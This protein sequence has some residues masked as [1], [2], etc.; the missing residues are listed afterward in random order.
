MKHG[1]RRAIFAAVFALVTEIV[2]HL[3]VLALAIL[4]NAMMTTT[5][6]RPSRVVASGGLIDVLIIVGSFLG[7]YLLLGM[8]G[9]PR[10]GRC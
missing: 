5:V 3:G 8:L 2:A 10:Q 9:K 4:S 7:S 6:S 1:L